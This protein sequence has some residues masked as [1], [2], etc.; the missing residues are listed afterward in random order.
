MGRG[1]A[2]LLTLLA[3]VSPL[4][5]AQAAA[6]PEAWEARFPRIA[7]VDDPDRRMVR[8][9]HANPEALEAARPGQPAPP[10][11]TLVLAEARARLDDAGR[12]LRDGAGRFLAEPG[13]TAILLQRKD[14]EAWTFAAFTGAGAP[15]DRPAAAC[16]ACH[17]AARAVQDHTFAFWDHVQGNR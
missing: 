8:H 10:G 15:S 6:L 16:A 5:A 7:T 17:A 2:L 11:T 9:I 3:A 14:R 13:W 1:P 12:P 4:G